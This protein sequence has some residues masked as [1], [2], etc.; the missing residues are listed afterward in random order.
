MNW[1][2]VW[3]YVDGV[4]PFIAM[5]K[6]NYSKKTFQSSQTRKIQFINI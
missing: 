6:M 5:S 3:E 1:K 4:K 2:D